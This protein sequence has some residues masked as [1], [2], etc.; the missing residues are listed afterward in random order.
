MFREFLIKKLI[1]VL[2]ILLIPPAASWSATYYVDNTAGSD[3][4][5]GTTSQPW[6]R[7]PGMSGWSGSATLAAGDTVYFD[8]A[9]TWTAS[10]GAALLSA[11]GGV[12]YDGETWGSGTGKATLQATGTFSQAV[13]LISADHAS[14]ETVIKG[15]EIDCGNRNNNGA[16]VNWPTSYNLTGAIKRLENLDIHNLY[17]TSGAY[18]NIK[19]GAVGGDTTRNVELIGNHIYNTNTTGIAIYAAVN[20]PTCL[21][22]QVLVKSNTV[23]PN[24]YP[25]SSTWN[26]TGIL[27]KNRT[28]NVTIEYNEIYETALNN[29]IVQDDGNSGS[30][31]N[32]GLIIRYNKIHNAIDKYGVTF[33]TP[34]GATFE[35]YDNDIYDNGRSGLEF[36]TTSGGTMTGTIYNNTF[37]NNATGEITVTDSAPRVEIYKNI[38]YSKSGQKPLSASS[39]T[40]TSHYNNLYYSPSG[41]TLVTYGASNYTS[42]NLSSFEAT[43]ISDDPQFIDPAV[44][45]FCLSSTSPAIPIDAGSVSGASCSISAPSSLQVLG[46][47]TLQ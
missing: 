1:V 21:I 28:K 41:G 9:D 2:A 22:D 39:D 43:A 42:S 4:N 26:G 11:T 10:S 13:A 27:L 34:N 20:C 15:F 44:G 3:S 5:P 30:D 12:L 18:Y 40:I 33:Q 35:I 6:Q 16:N 29:I 19:V 32:T 46:G 36:A 8:R 31:G 38:L 23:G 47:A 7:C 24:C 17:M 37:Y 25:A 45:N 14:Y